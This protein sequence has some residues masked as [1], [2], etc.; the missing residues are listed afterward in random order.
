MKQHAL[1][2]LL[3]HMGMHSEVYKCERSLWLQ[4]RY[5]G[6]A[7]RQLTVQQVFELKPLGADSLYLFT[8]RSTV[9]ESHLLHPQPVQGLSPYAATFFPK[10]ASTTIP[11]PCSQAEVR[12]G[13]LACLVCQKVWVLPALELWS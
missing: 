7:N 10:S 6:G 4:D 9:V 3:C 13:T 2:T 8:E 1:L 5:I 11:R 12:W